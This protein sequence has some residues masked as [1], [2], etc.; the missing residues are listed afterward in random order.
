MSPSLF[1]DKVSL[2][3]TGSGPQNELLLTG[4]PETFQPDYSE[5]SAAFQGV[6]TSMALQASWA[7]WPSAWK[8]SA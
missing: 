2:P 3:S 4:K 8:S 6:A 1:Q 7:L 5:C